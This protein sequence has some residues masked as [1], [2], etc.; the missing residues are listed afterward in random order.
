MNGDKAINVYAPSYTLPHVS[1][2][3]DLFETHLTFVLATWFDWITVF[4][5]DYR[6][7]N[8]FECLSGP[9][10]TLPGWMRRDIV[11][12]W[13]P[14]PLLPVPGFCMK[15]EE[16]YYTLPCNLHR[17]EVNCFHFGSALFCY[18]VT[19]LLIRRARD[20]YNRRACGSEAARWKSKARLCPP[21]RWLEY[22]SSLQS[23]W[24]TH[25]SE[26]TVGT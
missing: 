24:L 22:T 23:W 19:R 3:S 21:C 1:L 20:Q 15:G 25:T 9:R 6:T 13:A 14:A 8:R 12:I 18:N 5:G 10:F 26:L 2:F 16:K 7:D 11:L 4:R 17:A